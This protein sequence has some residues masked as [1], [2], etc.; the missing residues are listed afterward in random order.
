MKNWLKKAWNWLLNRT[1]IDEKVVEVVKE[2]KED[3]AEVKTRAKKVV[4]EAKEVK[5]AVK[6]VVKESKDVVDAAK[7]KPTTK[8]KPRRKPA[9]K[10]GSGNASAGNVGKKTT[11][12]RSAGNGKST[13]GKKSAG[14]VGK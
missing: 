7:G 2:V 1:T 5:E 12:G 13:S 9:A 4:K 3:V 10:R 11:K 8:R 14:S 6:K